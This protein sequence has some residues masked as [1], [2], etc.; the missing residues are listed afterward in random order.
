VCQWILIAGVCTADGPAHVRN[1]TDDN[2]PLVTGDDD[3]VGT[4]DL[5]THRPP[6]AG[7]PHAYE[8]FRRN[9]DGAIKVLLTP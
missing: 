4:E 2:L 8:I 3:P 6:L 7:A 5:A 1:W 9:Q